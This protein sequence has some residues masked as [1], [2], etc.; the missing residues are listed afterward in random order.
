MQ[1]DHW[2]TFGTFAEQNYFIYPGVDTYKGVIIN[3]N[4]A[5]YAPDGLAAFLLEKTP[6]LPYLIDPLT[7]AFQH[8]TNAIKNE[9]NEVKKSIFNLSGY[10]GDPIEKHV[11]KRPIL[12]EDFDN[13]ELRTF[14]ERCLNFQKTMVFRL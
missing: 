4:M 11:G 2:M 7:H 3:G 8:N 12:P 13:E 6:S 14:V 1:I 10:Y 5:A 9:K